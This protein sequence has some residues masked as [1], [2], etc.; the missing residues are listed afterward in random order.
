MFV[1]DHRLR[2]DTSLIGDLPLSRV[3]L[4]RDAN[5]P[6]CVL[7]PRREDKRE[8]FEPCWRSPERPPRP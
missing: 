7:V 5:Y 8:I 3:L 1:L 6:W 4:H 2:E